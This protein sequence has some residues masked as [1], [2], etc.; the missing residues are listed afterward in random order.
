[1]K[2]QAP[3]PAYPKLSK[4]ENEVVEA[5]IHHSTNEK[6][7]KNLKISVNTVK[8][9]LKNIYFKLDVHSRTELILKISQLKN[10]P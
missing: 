6:I 8:T 2:K 4:R 3:M 7:A 1:M 9:H 5:M 10:H